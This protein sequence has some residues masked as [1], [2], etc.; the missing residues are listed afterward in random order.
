MRGSEL[1][2]P[3]GCARDGSATEGSLMPDM[4]D[5]FVRETIDELLKKLPPEERLKGLPAAERVKG[6]TPDEL[7]EALPPEV[8]EGLRR[9]LQ[10]KKQSPK[11]E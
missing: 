1:A 9:K 5:Q 3:Q 4:L 2:F 10:D 6:M 8:L 11:P 7:L